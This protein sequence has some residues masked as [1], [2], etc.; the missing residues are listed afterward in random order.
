LGDHLLRLV[1]ERR[2]Q[3]IEKRSGWY[4]RA[5]DDCLVVL[6]LA[7]QDA[8]VDHPAGRLVDDVDDFGDGW[9]ILV[10]G[11]HDGTGLDQCLVTRVTR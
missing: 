4:D 11:D 5:L 3:M 2:E 7:R 6:K 8:E 1:T 10:T 9:C